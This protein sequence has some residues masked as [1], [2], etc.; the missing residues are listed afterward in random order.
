MED[1]YVKS[2]VFCYLWDHLFDSYQ[3]NNDWGM[4]HD[5]IVSFQIFFWM[6]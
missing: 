6:V 2:N 1:L 5:F 4:E 3:N